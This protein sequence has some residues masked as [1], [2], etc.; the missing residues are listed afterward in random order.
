MG[1][2]TKEEIAE[3]Y[4]SIADQDG[5][6]YHVA[7]ARKDNSDRDYDGEQ[8]QAISAERVKRDIAKARE[9]AGTFRERSLPRS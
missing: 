2:K 9:A 1:K 8:L 6:L 7:H 5:L 4:A 3:I